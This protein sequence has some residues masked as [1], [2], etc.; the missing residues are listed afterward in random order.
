[1]AAGGSW[2][3]AENLEELAFVAAAGGDHRDAATLTAAAT[4]I[5][6]RTGTRPHP[7][8]VAIADPYLAT[9][10]NDRAAWDA[11]WRSGSTMSLDDAI[12]LATGSDRT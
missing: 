1:V 12:E 4:S 10:R 9:A 2:D 3:L 11:G 7:F 6:E 8:D 5:R